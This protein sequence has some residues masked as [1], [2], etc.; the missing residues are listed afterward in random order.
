MDSRPTTKRARR[1]PSRPAIGVTAVVL[2]LVAA[3][4]G[5]SS[6]AANTGGS[7]N[8]STAK[9]TIGVLADQSGSCQGTGPSIVDGMKIAVDDVQTKGLTIGGKKY[10]IDL[11]VEDTASTN[12][13]AV[14]AT[15]SLIQDSGV[16]FILGPTC[17]GFQL[18]GVAPVA[19]KANVFYYSNFPVPA[20]G[21]P[22]TAVA[23]AKQF[24]YVFLD[25]P[26]TVDAAAGYVAG[27]TKFFPDAKNVYYLLDNVGAPLIPA[28]KAYF[29]Q[30]GVTMT[31][32]VYDVKTNDFGSLLAKAKAAHPDVLLYGVTQQP[33]LAILKQALDLGV[34][35]EYYTTNGSCCADPLSNAQ[36]KPIAS[37]WAGL[38]F[39][40][41]LEF[42]STDGAKHLAAALKTKNGK[43]RAED[44]F[45]VVGYDQ[46]QALVQAMVAAGSIDDVAKVSGAFSTT[47]FD[48]I[49]GQGITFDAGHAPKF[50]NQDACLVKDAK[51]TCDAIKYPPAGFKSPPLK[52]A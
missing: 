5:S 45:A 17:S 29:D 9:L 10:T 18:N 22:S 1:R 13:T 27:I 39:P 50:M 35:K 36:G 52:G 26:R 21:D 47:T 49:E 24:P 48:L 4:C 3:A 31:G 30:V 44:S 25:S 2:S 23:T 46:V 12:T 37:P 33:S 19:A 38:A 41:N 42:P 7:G 43:L 32:Q 8:A 15:N 11:K 16:K 28:E 51:V 14:A 40:A 34:A 6:K 20:M